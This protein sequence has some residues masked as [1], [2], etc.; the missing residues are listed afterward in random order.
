MRMSGRYSVL[1][2]NGCIPVLRQDIVW[3]KRIIQ[4]KGIEM[5]QVQLLTTPPNKRKSRLNQWMKKLMLSRGNGTILLAYYY[6]FMFLQ[7]TIRSSED[8][9]INTGRKKKAKAIMI[10]DDD[11]DDDLLSQYQN[12]N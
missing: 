2:K 10:Q 11:D 8:C 4:Y 3:R 1:M 9:D 5:S 6:S 7:R 12:G